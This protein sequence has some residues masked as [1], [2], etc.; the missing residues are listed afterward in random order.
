MIH[1]SP[2]G[3]ERFKLAAGG[4][5]GY[6]AVHKFGASEVVGTAWTTI[7]SNGGRYVYLAA[8]SILKISSGDVDDTSA[9]AGAQTVEI[10]GCDSNCDRIN[11]TVS[12]NGQT[13]VNT[14]NSYLRIWRMVV[15]SAGATGWNEGILYAGT[16]NVVAGVPDNI[17][18]TVPVLSSL[19]T[20]QTLMALYTVPTGT[21]GYIT[22]FNYTTPQGRDVE[23]QL[24]IRPDGEVFQTNHH[25]DLF[26]NTL[27]F[28]FQAPLPV[29]E[30]S[31]IEIIARSS[32][33]NTTMSATF[34]VTLI[35]N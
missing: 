25:V 24:M 30:K 21:T 23:A 27:N 15:R 4:I 10:F 17:F 9:G 22:H 11:E 1:N 29:T 14:V 6:E 8:A 26:Q 35:D 16:G 31:D 3:I 34:G 19:G 18:A 28:D 20:N 7:W 12:L 32:A 13:A 5:L 33:G 2:Q